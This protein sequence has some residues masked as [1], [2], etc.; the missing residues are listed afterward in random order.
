MI[1]V[2]IFGTMSGYLSDVARTAVVGNPTAFQRQTWS[3]L[4]ESR[5]ITLKMIKPGAHTRDIYLAF[6]KKF[7]ELGLK[8]IDFVGHGMGLTLHEEPYINKFA[9]TALEEGMV[10]CVEPYYMLPEKQMGF[11]IEDEVIVTSQ[12]YELITNYR[13]SSELIEIH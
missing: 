2:D 8:P 7:K 10:L 13:D 12:G 9:D 6:S 4:M 3:K 11:Q 1:R 5:A